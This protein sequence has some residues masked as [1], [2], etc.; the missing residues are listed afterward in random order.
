V[1]PRQ[2]TGHERSRARAIGFGF[3]FSLGFSFIEPRGRT[4]PYLFKAPSAPSPQ[5]G[6]VDQGDGEY[7]NHVS[8]NVN[9]TE[10]LPIHAV[11]GP[12]PIR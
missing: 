2:A 7:S 8:R 10:G 6:W 1:A 3:S 12:V 11:S 9:A 5:Y 4:L